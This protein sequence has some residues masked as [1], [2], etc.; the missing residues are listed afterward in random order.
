[1]LESQNQFTTNAFTTGV[2]GAGQTMRTAMQVGQQQQEALM[3]NKTTMQEGVLNRQKEQDL[4]GQR[5]AADKT[6]YERS[7]ADQTKRDAD[8]R[9]NRLD[10]AAALR[11]KSLD[12][13]AE[14]ER[15]DR[16]E[17]ERRKNEANEKSDKTAEAS[18]KG[19]YSGL[20]TTWKAADESSTDWTDEVEENVGEVTEDD[21][22]NVVTTYGTKK[23]SKLRERVNQHFEDVKTKLDKMGSAAERTAY[24]ER[25]KGAG[26]LDFGSVRSL[27]DP[28]FR[29][30]MAEEKAEKEKAGAAGGTVDAGSG[31]AVR[32]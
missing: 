23:T 24:L 21:E 11:Q 8:A 7:L 30:K 20:E 5:L 1:M 26:L 27:Y 9:Q 16:E 29:K 32:I 25:L 3:R 17:Y 31:G 22:G 15:R 10:D 14:R 4:L 6:T 2:Q 18:Y 12:D 19:L 28:A 13:Q